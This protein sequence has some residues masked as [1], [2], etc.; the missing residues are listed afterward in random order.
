MPFFLYVNICNC[1]GAS[2]S[3]GCDRHFT[4]HQHQHR[5]I[6]QSNKVKEKDTSQSCMERMEIWTLQLPVEFLHWTIQLTYCPSS[7]LI[8]MTD[9]HLQQGQNNEYLN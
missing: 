5:V 9:L 3:G 2:K 8:F 7:Y 1:K 4:E 6:N